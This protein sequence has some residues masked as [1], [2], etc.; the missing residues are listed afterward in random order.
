MPKILITGANGF[1]GRA[2]SRYFRNLGWT[3]RGAGRSTAPIKPHDYDEWANIDLADPA[4]HWQPHLEGIDCVLHLGGLAHLPADQIHHKEYFRI[5]T[6]ATNYLSHACAT[7][8]ISRFVF[9]SSIGVNGQTSGDSPFTESR[10][11]QPENPY[12]E[13]KYQAEIQIQETLNPSSTQW[14]IF[15]PPLTYGPGA[16]GNFQRLSKLIASGWPLPLG[17]ATIPRSYLGLDNLLDAIGLAA[18]DSR[19]SNQLFLISDGEDLS[20]AELIRLIAE[21]KQQRVWLPKVPAVVLRKLAAL[22]G[23]ETDVRRLFEPLRIDASLWTEQLQWKAPISLR[24][25]IKRAVNT[26]D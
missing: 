14:V 2:A 18:T 11:P 1:I 25:G 10:Q 12:A 20:T 16:P 3:I 21:Y 15:R 23:R 19:A 9:L 5:N 26:A 22:V 4:P 17:A 6:D 7:Q 13:S 24:D 8:G